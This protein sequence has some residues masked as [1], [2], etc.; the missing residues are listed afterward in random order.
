MEIKVYL[1]G[2]DTNPFHKFGLTQNPFPQTAKHEWDAACLRLQALGGDPIPNRQY[3]RDHL[4]GWVSD[5]LI[6]LC[7]DRFEQ[8]KMVKFVIS[9]PTEEDEG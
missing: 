4:R 1:N 7:V 3:I 5:E 9:F 2:T 8:G 6:N